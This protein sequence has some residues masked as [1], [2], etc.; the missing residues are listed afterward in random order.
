ME[1]ICRDLIFIRKL[2]IGSGAQVLNDWFNV[3][4]HPFYSGQYFMDVTVRFPFPEN[5]F[6]FIRSEH[7]IE[8]VHYLDAMEM[9]LECHRVIRA[10]GFIRIAT[11]DLRKLA[12]L[13][14]TPLS[15]QQRAYVHAVFERWRDDYESSEVGVVINNIFS[16]QHQF[17]YDAGTL[18]RRSVRPGLQMSCSSGR[19]TRITPLLWAQM[20]MPLNATTSP[21]KP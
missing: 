6:D 17:I 7:M 19:G 14:N 2:N 4:L 5:A 15:E 13:Y 12:Q 3:D 18:E 20:P 16:F 9:L 21:S 1:R 10:G 8:H 11:P